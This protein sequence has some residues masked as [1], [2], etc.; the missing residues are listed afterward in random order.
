MKHFCF[1]MRNEKPYRPATSCRSSWGMSLWYRAHPVHCGAGPWAGTASREGTGHVPSRG[2]GVA[3]F[4]PPRSSAAWICTSEFISY[5]DSHRRGNSGKFRIRQ[6]GRVR[7]DEVSIGGFP[8]NA[9]SCFNWAPRC[10]PSRWPAGR[11]QEEAGAWAGGRA[12]RGR[13]GAR[14]RGREGARPWNGGALSQVITLSESFDHKLM[15]FCCFL[16]LSL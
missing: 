15:E 13:E 2:P 6:Q 11:R 9:S 16:L 1:K 5:R 12:P 8:R 3:G 14:P 4:R 10:S 7:K